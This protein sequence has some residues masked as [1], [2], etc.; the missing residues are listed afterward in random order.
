[1]LVHVHMPL[2]P[3]RRQLIIPGAA[4]QA[5]HAL[6]ASASGASGRNALLW[7]QLMQGRRKNTRMASLHLSSMELQKASHL[8]LSIPGQI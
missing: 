4:R 1:M 6:Q 7:R 3:M 5:R 8:A 2:V